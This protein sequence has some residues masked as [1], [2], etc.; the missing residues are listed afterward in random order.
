MAEDVNPHKIGDK[1]ERR[2]EKLRDKL[3]RQGM[4]RDHAEK[5]AYRE[6]ARDPSAGGSHAAG[7]AAKNANAERDH[8]RG[9]DKEP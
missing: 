8:R 2:A 5:E 9:S 4:G 1:Q 7:E 3:E 6:V